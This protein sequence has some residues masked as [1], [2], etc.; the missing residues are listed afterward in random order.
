MA[1]SSELAA[2]GKVDQAAPFHWLNELFD[3][4]MQK[5]GEIQDSAATGG[6]AAATSDTDQA[7]PPHTSWSAAKPKGPPPGPK[8]TVRQKEA[9]EQLTSIRLRSVP[10]RGLEATDQAT[11]FHTSL[12]VAVVAV[13]RVELVPTA[14]QKETEGH[15]TECK[16]LSPSVPLGLVTTDQ[17]EPFQSSVRVTG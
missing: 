2:T 6:A 15:D 11:P 5:E 17:V 10:P 16:V 1:S 14:R 3:A 9:D 7:L 13:P 12:K 8:P 4:A